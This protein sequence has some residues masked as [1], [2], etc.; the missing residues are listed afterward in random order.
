MQKQF[1]TLIFLFQF[2]SQIFAQSFNAS[3][4]KSGMKLFDDGDYRKAIPYLLEAVQSDPEAN[5]SKAIEANFFLGVSYLKIGEGGNGLTYMQ[6]VYELDKDFYPEID[7]MMGQCA[8]DAL[9]FDVA[10]KYYENFLAME[11]VKKDP[12]IADEVAKHIN[13]CKTAKKLIT[14]PV[15]AKIENVGPII[16]GTFPDYTPVITADESIMIFTSRREGNVG[17]N[18]ASYLDQE[19]EFP[20]ED[21]YQSTKIN[22]KWSE[23]TNLGTTVNTQDHDAA[24]ALSPDGNQLFI[25]KDTQKGDIYLSQK[26]GLDWSKPESLGDKINLPKSSEQSCSITSDGKTLYFSSD[27][28]GGYG[29]LDIWKSQ[30]IKGEWSEPQNMGP[31]LNSKEDE[32]SPFIHPDGI[33]LY[34]S[35]KGKNTMGGYDIVRTTLEKGGWSEPENLGYPINSVQNDIYFVLSADNQHGYYASYK[36]GGYGKHDIYMISM[37]QAED[38]KA[39]EVAKANTKIAG[40]GAAGAGQKNIAPVALTKTKSR[41]TLLKGVIKDALTKQPIE[42]NIALLNNKTGQKISEVNSNSATGAYLIILPAGKNYAITV[43]KPG[44]LFHSENFD[45]S[46][47]AEFQEIIKNVDLNKAQVGA[48]IV[49]RNIFFDFDKATLRPESNIEIERLR[50]VLI[51]YPTMKIELSGHTDNKGSSDYNKKLSDSRAKAVLDYL[52]KKGISP[53]RMTSVGYGFDRPMAPNDTD[54]GRQLNRR[55]EFEIKAF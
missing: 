2:S 28:P 47:T 31:K 23:P 27:R 30:K 50:K 4:Q 17:K 3:A 37:P 35:T 46:D 26:K 33:T 22:D 19:E 10:L 12:A 42:A 32:D 34:Y 6:K 21:I 24:I 44:Y 20:M 16:N 11:G 9:K 52:V 13:E 29:G 38:V 48:K 18:T 14:N 53:D 15:K 36:E 43:T 7:Y 41:V 39:I 1:L 5:S 25:Y 40:A 45:L 55:T 8:E 51:E 54:A 49:L